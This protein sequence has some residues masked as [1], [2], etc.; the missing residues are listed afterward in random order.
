MFGI[1]VTITLLPL[2][3]F[4]GGAILYG[5]TALVALK[6]KR[7]NVIINRMV[8]IA[9]LIS[10]VLLLFV[11]ANEAI[12]IIRFYLGGVFFMYAL[13]RVK[14]NTTIFTRVFYGLC[15]LEAIYIRTIG[16]YPGYIE[17]KFS[18][19]GLTVFSRTAIGENSLRVL[20]PSFNSSITGSIIAIILVMI[21]T[22]VVNKREELFTEN[23]NRLDICALVI[24][25]LLCGSVSGYLILAIG[26][27]VVASKYL[28]R[29]LKTYK[30]Q[31]NIIIITIF[32]VTAIAGFLGTLFGKAIIQSKL[33]IEYLIFIINDKIMA[34]NAM[35]FISLLL[36]ETEIKSSIYGAQISE[37]GGDFI[38]LNMIVK[39]GLVMTLIYL[40]S[41]YYYSC[42]LNIRLFFCL[43]LLGSVHYGVMFSV[44]GQLF[45]AIVFITQLRGA[46]QS[47]FILRTIDNNSQ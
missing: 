18:E 15:L 21:T 16:S 4:G 26:L 34:V 5:F 22:R 7:G 24:T 31:K 12:K 45:L 46:E 1:I 13:Y 27:L 41:L 8:L 3:V 37:L 32:A 28:M 47:S 10:F 42:V 17:K 36:P 39:M 11:E 33:N 25:L 2:Y 30:V 20:G 9:L 23:L 35:D 14:I 6:P 40:A 29:T 38:L 19:V 44:V 43:A